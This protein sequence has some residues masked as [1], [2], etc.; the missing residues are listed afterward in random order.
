MAASTVHWQPSLINWL[1]VSPLRWQGITLQFNTYSFQGWLPWSQVLYLILH[2]VLYTVY[3]SH[4]TLVIF[5][6]TPFLYISMSLS[7]P[8]RLH[9]MGFANC[10]IPIN[11][12]KHAQGAGSLQ[13]F[14]L[15]LAQLI[16]SIILWFT[17]Y[18]GTRHSGNF[19]F[20]CLCVSLHWT[21]VSSEVQR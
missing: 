18:Y 2:S 9:M 4:A 17:T 16:A 20:T 19:L 13:D 15:P 6:Y 8:F 10:K 21:M 1:E 5:F 11:P 12:L 3:A 7:M 14:L